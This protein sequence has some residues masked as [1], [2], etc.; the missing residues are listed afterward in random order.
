MG[1]KSRGASY[2]KDEIS[3]YSEKI[4]E[5]D[6]IQNLKY[7]KNK[8]EKN[9]DIEEYSQ[10]EY[11]ESKNNNSSYEEKVWIL[12]NIKKVKRIKKINLLKVGYKICCGTND[13]AIKYYENIRENLISEENIIQNYLDEYQ[14]LK[15]NNIPKKDILTNIK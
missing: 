6:K 11:S 13:K 4:E 15:L 8:K 10:K 12:T 1:N 14:L 2:K 3:N 9:M 7:S 5:H